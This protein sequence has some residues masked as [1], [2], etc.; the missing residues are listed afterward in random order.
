MEINIKERRPIATRDKPWAQN[1]A[2]WLQHKGVT[3]N[4]ISF[5]SM[6]CALV[7]G[8]A[9]W[10]AFEWSSLWGRGFC[11]LLAAIMIQG[12]LLCNLLDGMVA[13]EGG[14]AS[15]AGPV[16]NELPDRVS[17]SLILIGAGYGLTLL[18]YS[19]TLGWC[20]ALL[21]LMTAYLRLL[22]GVCGLEQQFLGPMAKQH[23]MAVL[24]GGALLA[25]FLPVYWGQSV[26][27]LCLIV[28]NIGAF[29]TCWRRGKGILRGLN[30][31]AIS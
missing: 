3:P 20:A 27:F 30:A 19:A 1:S 10:L 17:D 4:Q 25:L 18:P 13:V 16:W 8:I 11:L 15:P 29:I 5:A 9:L 6:G 21:A 23:R 26:L 14:M 31:Q 22:G 28:I 2:R 12:R 24:C 7:A